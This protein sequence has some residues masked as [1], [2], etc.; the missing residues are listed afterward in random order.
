M[1][2]GTVGYFHC[3]YTYEAPYTD[4]SGKRVLLPS[5]TYRSAFYSPAK[6]DH[7]GQNEWFKDKFLPAAEAHIKKNYYGDVDRNNKGRTYERY[8]Q[9]YMVHELKFCEK[10]PVHHEGRFKGQPYGT[11]I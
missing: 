4:Q 10:L 8:N 11:Q 6:K 1:S 2:H 7:Q 5:P 9:K 3:A